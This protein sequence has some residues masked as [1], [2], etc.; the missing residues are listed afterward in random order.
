MTKTE[1]Q[2]VE[3]NQK[4]IDNLKYLIQKTKKKEDKSALAAAFIKG[5]ERKIKEIK[6]A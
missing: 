1:K 2:T 6:N 5:L 3:V 4:E